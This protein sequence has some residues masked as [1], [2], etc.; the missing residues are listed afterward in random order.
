MLIKRSI[1]LIEQPKKTHQVITHSLTRAIFYNK[2]AM[3]YYTE[4][5]NTNKH[6]Q[7]QKQTSRDT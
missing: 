4:K 3:K 6:A 5:S 7:T 1:T 2:P